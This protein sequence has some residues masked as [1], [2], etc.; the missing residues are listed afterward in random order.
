MRIRD[1]EQA[2]RDHVNEPRMNHLLRK[3]QAAWG[4]ITSSLDVIGDTNLATQAYLAQP[5]DSD[6]GNRYIA[7]YGVLQALFLQQDAVLNLCDALGKPKDLANYPRLKDIRDTRNDSIG[8]PTKRDRPKPTSYHHISRQSLK[9]EGF[10]L[11]SVDDTG[12]H[13]FRDVSVTQCIEDQSNLIEQI[14]SELLVE[15]NHDQEEHKRTFMNDKLES[16]FPETLGHGFEKLFEGVSGRGEPALA[17]YGTGQVRSVI[18]DLRTKLEARGAELGTYGGLTESYHYIEFSLLHLERFLK[19][20][21]ESAI[22]D[23]TEGYIFTSF[24][25][26]QVDDLRAL[27]RE[28]DNDYT[29]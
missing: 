19:G 23:A 9:R 22:S 29:N 13:Q 21:A 27:A 11:L 25:K 3:S 18:D 5:V 6:F 12:S 17:L 8:H 24:L 20:E 14:L 26:E 16:S 4:Q 15:L 7:A 10:T 1:L 28:I 2:I